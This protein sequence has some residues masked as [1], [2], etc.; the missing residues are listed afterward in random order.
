M[1]RA[2]NTLSYLFA[3]ERK[4]R[5]HRLVQKSAIVEHHTPETKE[6]T[7]PEFYELMGKI[8]TLPEEKRLIEAMVNYHR[9]APHG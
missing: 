1:T 5:T 8:L 3:K 9:M 2:K 4:A 7:E 6:L